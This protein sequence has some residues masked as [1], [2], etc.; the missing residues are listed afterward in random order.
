LEKIKIKLKIENKNILIITITTMVKQIL[1]VSDFTPSSTKFSDVKTNRAGGKM[2]YPN[3]GGQN[4]VL[5]TPKLFVPFGVRQ[6]DSDKVS[7]VTVTTS[8]KGYDQ[9]G[10]AQ[11]L[12]CQ[13]L[14]ELDRMVIKEAVNNPEWQKLLGMK[15]NK[16]SEET[17]EMLY[18]P[19]VKQS[20]GYAPNFNVKMPVEYG[21]TDIKT[22][23]Y[24]KKKQIKLDLENVSEHLPRFSEVKFLMRVGS[25]WF[26]NKKFGVTIRAVQA[27]V[28][29]P[30]G[31]Q[32]T[33]FPVSEVSAADLTFSD[34]KKNKRGGSGVY[35][36]MKGAS[37]SLALPALKAP[38]GISSYANDGKP[39]SLTLS[40]S[41]DGYQTVD[42]VKEVHQLLSGLDDA[43]LEQALTNKE[44][45]PI[46]GLSK[47]KKISKE[48]LEMLYTPMVKH[49]DEKYPPMIAGKL[50]LDFETQ[51]LRTKVFVEGEEQTDLTSE[52]VLEL[53]QNGSQVKATL[54]LGGVWFIGKKFGVSLRVEKLELE[55]SSEIQGYSFEDSDDELDEDFEESDDEVESDAEESDVEESDVEDEEEEVSDV[56]DE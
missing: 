56:D 35:L 47:K 41:L 14:E 18:V 27:V 40:L 52:S 55:K 2:V 51:K 11:Q 38:F 15:K 37:A 19:L 30:T 9:E 39:A 28:Y 45:H 13:K 26:I 1:K 21:T 23:L 36:K 43:L 42:E 54:Q 17:V 7:S 4:I 25:V 50:Q 22:E 10:T 12:F 46:I 3:V 34:V 20:E 48:T 53:V 32:K 24:H 6:P 33:V 29:P 8:I 5:Q 44:W 31:I 49:N 16:V